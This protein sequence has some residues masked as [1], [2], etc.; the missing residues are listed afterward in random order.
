MNGGRG[1]NDCVAVFDL[2][3]TNMKV[4]VFDA[5]GKVVAERGRPTRRSRRT[6]DGRTGG[7]TPKGPGR[8]SS[9]R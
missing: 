6:R 1:M 7:S 3:K 5:A 4:V 9:A 2:G 8:S